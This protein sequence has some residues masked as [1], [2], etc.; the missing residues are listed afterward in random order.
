MGLDDASH[1][2]RATSLSLCLVEWCTIRTPRPCPAGADA[3]GSRSL[4]SMADAAGGVDGM[5][6]RCWSCRLS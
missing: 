3:G 5:G 1:M 6:G 2:S 4:L